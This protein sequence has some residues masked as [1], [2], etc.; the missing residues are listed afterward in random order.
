M[1]WGVRK[2]TGAAPKAAQTGKLE[3]KVAGAK[4]VASE[5]KI[6][7][8]PHVLAAQVKSA[9]NH[10]SGIDKYNRLKAEV[11]KGNANKLDDDDLKFLN[12]RA[13]AIAKANKAFN[14]QGSW[15][16]K[17]VQT[18]VDNALQTQAKKAANLV[19]EKYIGAKLEKKLKVKIPDPT[20][21]T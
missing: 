9:V 20:P 1:K 10:E 19:A 16:Q 8:K 6:Q 15:L 3:T 11:K 5:V 7:A 4:E 12:S 13:D 18:A 14:Q 21:A 17:T 2:P